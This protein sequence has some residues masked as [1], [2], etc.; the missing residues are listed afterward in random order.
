M[1]DFSLYSTVHEMSKIENHSC[2]KFSLHVC[3][4]VQ[5]A[6]PKIFS[7]QSYETNKSRKKAPMSSWNKGMFGILKND[8]ID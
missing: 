3:C 6:D 1:I 2:E 5:P 4:F 8:S 7:L